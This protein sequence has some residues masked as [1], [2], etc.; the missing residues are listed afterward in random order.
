MKKNAPNFGAFSGSDA[1]AKAIASMVGVGKTTVRNAA[2]FTE[3][4]E[5]VEQVSPKATSKTLS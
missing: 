2:K 1:T 4:L 5:A 3:A